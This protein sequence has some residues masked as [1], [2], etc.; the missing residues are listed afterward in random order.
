MLRGD[1][2]T[3]SPPNPGRIWPATY[4]LVVGGL[5]IYLSGL[6]CR[7]LL[8][9][10]PAPRA[11][12]TVD[13]YLVSVAFVMLASVLRTT[14]A[15]TDLGATMAVSICECLAVTIFA[16]GSARSWQAKVARFTTGRRLASTP[17]GHRP[18]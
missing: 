7:L 13:S 16:Y 3:S 6:P 17:P 15:W 8:I 5:V 18:V 1:V 4:L 9:L 14:T 10:R 11:A 2:G 12:S